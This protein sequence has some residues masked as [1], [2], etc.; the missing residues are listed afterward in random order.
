MRNDGIF[1]ASRK[2]K[3]NNKTIISQINAKRLSVRIF[4]RLKPAFWLKSYTYA[5]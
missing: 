3:Q 1:Y 5:K 2:R 4:L